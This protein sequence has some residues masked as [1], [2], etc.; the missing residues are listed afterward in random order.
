MPSGSEFAIELPSPLVELPG[1]PGAG[2]G[3]RLLLKRDDLLHPEV[4]GTKWR[5]LRDNLALARAQ[6][7]RRLLTFGGAYS[8]HLR[9]TAAAGRHFG[10]GTIGVVRGEEHRPLNESLA[11]AERQGMRLTYLDR[12]TYRRKTDPDVL[13][14][15]TG[16]FGPAYLIPEGGGNGPAV[17]G[18]AEL[19]GEI[20]EDFDVLCCACGTGA[21]LAGLAAGLGPRQRA[22]GFPVL[23][24]GRF[25]EAEVRRLQREAF[26]AETGNWSLDCDFAFGGYARRTAA[27]DAF[28]ADFQ[29]RHGVGLDRVYEAKMMYGLFQRIRTG[30]FARGTTVVALLC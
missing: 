6:G 2:R 12:T 13:A 25:L 14:A 8:S 19:P 28:I 4:P 30:T 23:K 18:C 27:L 5:K 16:R 10:F 21:T 11:Y 22:I 15:L 9:A 24:G 26:G 17:R 3:V 7:H 1:G 29:H 20:T